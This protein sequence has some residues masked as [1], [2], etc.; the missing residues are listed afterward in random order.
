MVVEKEAAGN[1]Q[2]GIVTDR[3]LALKV[4]AGDALAEAIP[5]STVMSE[6]LLTATEIEKIYNLLQRMQFRGV[7]RVPVI[8]EKGYLSGILTADD[9]LEFHIEELSRIINIIKKERPRF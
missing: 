8:D 7:R 2:V 4:V 6:K 3:D 1:K 5:V 9:I